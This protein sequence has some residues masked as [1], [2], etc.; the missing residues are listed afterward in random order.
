MNTLSAG[1]DRRSTEKHMQ[2]SNL[3]PEALIISFYVTSPTLVMNA[4]MLDV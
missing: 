4:E 2:T 3:A 1:A